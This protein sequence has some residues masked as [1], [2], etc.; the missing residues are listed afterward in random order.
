MGRLVAAAC[1]SHSPG[2][3]GFPDAAE[4]G[5]ARRVFEGFAELARSLARL[6]PDALVLVSAEHY[7]NFFVANLPSFAVGTAPAYELPANDAFAEF[8][9]IDRRSYPGHAALGE[10]LYRG[11]LARDFDP[12]LVAGGYGFD[13]GFAVPLALLGATEAPVPVVPVVVNAVHDP[14]PPL[15]RC[16][17]LGQALARAVDDQDAAARV[18]VIGT[19][20]LSH[21]VGLPRAGEIDEAF[22]ARVLEALAEGRGAELCKLRDDEVE[23]AGN[24]AHE[25]RTWLAVAGAA[26]NAPFEVLAYEAVPAWLTGTCVARARLGEQGGTQ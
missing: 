26:G 18:A 11:L 8:L 19:G 24:G 7:T 22:D 13:E 17:A 15:A 5:A 12:S 20:G 3:T 25:I 9:G 14:Y 6:R 10:S 1:V 4:Q 16:H 2:L 23:A 21:W